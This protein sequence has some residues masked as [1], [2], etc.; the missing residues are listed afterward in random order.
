MCHFVFVRLFGL[1]TLWMFSCRWL[2][3]GVWVLCCC[4]TDVIVR[5]VAKR[6]HPECSVFHE[7]T[8]SENLL[9]SHVHVIL[10]L[11]VNVN[12]SVKLQQIFMIFSGFVCIDRIGRSRNV[13]IECWSMSVFRAQS[14]T[15][16]RAIKRRDKN[17][18]RRRYW[19]RAA[20]L[21]WMTCYHLRIVDLHVGHVHFD[22]ELA[23]LR[24]RYI[25]ELELHACIV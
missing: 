22:L 14:L 4:Q 23:K 6:W 8:S 7:G 10:C 13:D 18:L 17:L 11:K 25:D 1:C 24:W 9:E 15:D 3:V 20:T 12:K 2:I 5:E 19:G 21:H 16:H